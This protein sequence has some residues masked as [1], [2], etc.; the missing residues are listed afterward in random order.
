VVAAVAVGALTVSLSTMVVGPAPAHAADPDPRPLA[1]AAD[2]VASHLVDGT[3]RGDPWLNEPDY[4]ATV[5][6]AL[7][8]MAAGGHDDDVDTIVPK[9]SD[10]IMKYIEDDY[11]L[12]VAPEDDVWEQYHLELPLQTAKALVLA[13][14]LDEPTETG[15]RDP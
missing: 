11:I 9:V 1:L 10:D 3:V 4:N 14:S 6:V 13:Q 5:D 12:D 15:R 2:Y 8:L 7:T